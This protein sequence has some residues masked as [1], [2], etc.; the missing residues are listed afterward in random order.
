MYSEYLTEY[1]WGNEENIRFKGVRCQLIGANYSYLSSSV[2]WQTIKFKKPS[3]IG[4]A[5][6][7]D[8]NLSGFNLNCLN[9][10]TDKFSNKKYLNQLI[11]KNTI[12]YSSYDNFRATLTEL[13]NH[14]N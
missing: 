3:V 5:V 14:L 6:R 4:I 8:K 1:S 9:E 2:F 7:P 11:L 10:K 13:K 12:L